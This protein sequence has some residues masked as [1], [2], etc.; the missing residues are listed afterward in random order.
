MKTD[1]SD[2]NKKTN[3]EP[4]S[5]EEMAADSLKS[6]INRMANQFSSALPNK[7]GVERMMRIVMTAILNNPKLALCEPNSFFGALLHALQLGLEVNTPLGQAYLIP[8][9][10]KNY[11]GYKCCLQLGYQGLLDLCYRYRYNNGKSAYRQITAQIVYK[12]DDFSYRYGTSQF[13]NHDPKDRSD[14]PAYVWALYELDNGGQRF[15]VW[16]WEKVMRHAE[17]F[18][19]S[20]DEKTGEWKYS[21]WSS[22]QE[23]KESMAQKTVLHDLLKYAPKSVEIAQAI[24][25]DEKIIIARPV[26][27]GGEPKFQFDISQQY[28]E[29]DRN[30]ENRVK[31]EAPGTDKGE[32][33]GEKALVTA[34]KPQTEKPAAN[35]R[36][37]Q[38]PD[39]VPASKP[40][41]HGTR[42]GNLFFQDEE[43]ALEEQYQQQI[44][45][46]EP[47]DFY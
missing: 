20:Y 43:S 7:I 4:K 3:Q 31:E 5:P 32:D 9:W 11:K 27:E 30:N 15:V 44:D 8:R 33:K 1:G 18:S 24:S 26:N 21:A 45:G 35:G 12:G 16:T 47:P 29:D 17:Q 2:K 37:R 10:D 38:E 39:P 25:A 14:I 40:R 19:E 13:L 22:N 23:S 28:L 42:T 34:A 46:V 41:D 6:Q 36:N